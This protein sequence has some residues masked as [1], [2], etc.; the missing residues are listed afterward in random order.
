MGWIAW[1]AGNFGLGVGDV[2]GKGGAVFAV[3]AGVLACV[4]G[5]A[6]AQGRAAGDRPNVIYILADDLG[7]GDL[8]CTGQT[9]FRTPNIDRLAAEGMRF[10]DHYC[11]STVCMPSRASL[12]TG[13]HQGHVSIRGNRGDKRLRPDPQEVTVAGV[14][15]RS[16]YATAN[17]GKTGVTNSDSAEAVLEKGFDVFVGQTSHG[18][19]HR[20]Y[21]VEIVRNLERQ[22]IDGNQGREGRVYGNQIYFDE[23]IAFIKA[24]KDRPMFVHIAPTLPH[25]DLNAPPEYLERFVGRFDEPERQPPEDATKGYRFTKHPKATYVAMVTYLDDQV[26]RVMEAVRAEGLDENTIILFA[27]DN[28]AM[29]EGGFERTWFDSSGKLRGGKRDLYEGGIR[30]P[31]LVRWPGMIEAGAVTDHPSAFWDVLPTLAELAGAAVP[32]GLDGISFRPTLLS[33]P[34]EQA[35]HKYLYWEFH[36][37]GGKQ[38]VRMGKW[39]GVR[40]N[41]GQQPA[42]PIE[43][44]DLASDPSEAT[45]VAAEH[46]EVVRQ[47]EEIMVTARTP[48]KIYQ[49]DRK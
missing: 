5:M 27:S 40:L 8:S 43:L 35:A 3:A 44:Y 19:A 34:G 21:P 1:A 47:I 29:N 42:G 25:A 23:A 15:K 26:G 11:G 37:Q 22:T 38:A 48:S 13:L 33:K 9:H 32:A 46:V 7:Y 31:L 30:T 18:A 12:L 41:V 16:G 28:G 49:F 6:D 10:T 39:K 4:G 14:L 24:N 36:E 45:N 20:Q 2:W 17:F